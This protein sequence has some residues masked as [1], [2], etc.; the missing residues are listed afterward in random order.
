MTTFPVPDAALVPDPDAQWWQRPTPQHSWQPV[1]PA[2]LGGLPAGTQLCRGGE[3]RVRSVDEG[4]GCWCRP[5]GAAGPGRWVDAATAKAAWARGEELWWPGAAAWARAPAAEQVVEVQTAV[6]PVEVQAVAA[7]PW[8]TGPLPRS[9]YTINGQTFE[10]VR[11]PP[12]TFMMGSPL[13]EQGRRK[14]E[15]QVKVSIGRTAA[16]SVFPVTQALWQA[17]M[18]KNP[19]KFQAFADAPHRPVEMVSWLDAVEFCNKASEACEL[20]P[21]YAIGPGASPT[22]GCN[23]DAFGFRLPTEAEWEYA[24]RAGGAYRFLY[25]GSDTLNEVGWYS[26]NAGQATQPVGRKLPNSWGLHDMSGNVSE[27]CGDEYSVKLPGGKDPVGSESGSYRVRRG[28]SWLNDPLSARV[29]HRICVGPG[30]RFGN[31]GVRLVRTVP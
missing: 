10:M 20:P 9:S 12:G 23:F 17:V 30:S 1:A 13:S 6:V 16:V 2:A 8:P 18:D 4:R 22:V 19:S 25:A 11:V 21:V 24:A 28:G 7:A 3:Q 29:A 5:A 15:R 31:L 14:D 27:W 26:G